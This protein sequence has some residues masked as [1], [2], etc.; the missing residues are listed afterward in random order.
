LE[1]GVRPLDV[2]E[3]CEI[4]DLRL[5]LETHAA[6]R[7]AVHRTEA[8]LREI[9]AALECMRELTERYIAA[10]DGKPFLDDIVREDV[11]FHLGILAAAKNNLMRNEI[12]AP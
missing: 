3:F 1:R 9:Q 12:L 11:R 7:A 4:C 2:N 10:E 6:A 5:A 8:D